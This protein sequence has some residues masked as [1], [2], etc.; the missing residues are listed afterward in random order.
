MV[1][2][3]SVQLSA[4]QKHTF[5]PTKKS[6]SKSGIKPEI[7]LTSSALQCIESIFNCH[8]ECF[9]KHIMKHL[10]PRG[11]VHPSHAPLPKGKPVRRRLTGFGAHVRDVQTLWDIN[12]SLYV[13]KNILD[14]N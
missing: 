13:L 3:L 14:D 8:P 6:K 4:F 2:I 5:H 11:F 9:S 10:Y 1:E 12:V 7:V